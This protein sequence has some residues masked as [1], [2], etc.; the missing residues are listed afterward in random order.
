LI[1]FLPFVFTYPANIVYTKKDKNQEWEQAMSISDSAYQTKKDKTGNSPKLAKANAPSAEVA[2]ENAKQALPSAKST[3]VD[4]EAI[5]KNIDESNRVI[6]GFA[7]D[8]VSDAPLQLAQYALLYASQQDVFELVSDH[9]GMSQHTFSLAKVSFDDSKAKSACGEGTK[10]FCSTPVGFVIKEEIVCWQAPK[11]YGYAILN[12]TTLLPQHLGL[13][14]VEELDDHRTLLMWRTY[15]HGRMVGGLFART[16]LGVVLPDM[17]SNFAK[18][19]KGT[20]LRRDKVR[21]LI[22][23]M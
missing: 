11:I 7:I 23:E 1:D 3:T 2:S 18:V 19:F 14:Q 4:K 20:I 15:F 22:N 5:M 9:E 17:V 21:R 16:A 13:V 12:A 10:R 8:S 6:H